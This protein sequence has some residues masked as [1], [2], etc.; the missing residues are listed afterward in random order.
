[1][2]YLGE[3][4]GVHCGELIKGAW[5]VLE[6]SQKEAAAVVAGMGSGVRRV[7]MLHSGAQHRL[8]W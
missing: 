8:A 3:A 1:M 2:C 4:G 5:Q 6:C 7:G